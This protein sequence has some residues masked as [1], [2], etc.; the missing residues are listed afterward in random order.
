MMNAA[1]PK[2]VLTAVLAVCF[3]ILSIGSGYLVMFAVERI[4]MNV[5]AEIYQT[6]GK[7]ALWHGDAPPASELE[8]LAAK[9]RAAGRLEAESAFRQALESLR[10]TG[11]LVL[12]APPVSPFLAW[13]ALGFALAALALLILSKR[14]KTDAAQTV[15]GIIAGLFVWICIELGL[16]LAARDLGI[17]KRFD[18]LNGALIGVRGEFVLLKYS[19]VFLLPVILYL[20]FQESV[21]CNLFV[22]LRKKLHLMRGAAATGRIDNY[23]PRVTFY[24]MSSIWTFYVILLWAFD[25]RIFGA[26]SG[27]TYLFFFICLACTVY[28]FYR[29]LQQSGPGAVLRYA[30]AVALVLWSIIEI[31]I[32]WDLLHGPWLSYN[33]YALASCAL[34]MTAGGAMIARDMRKH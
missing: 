5:S 24:Y 34:A 11:K 22:F 9:N 6:P 30:I 32:K 26:Q 10:Q 12:T 7:Q 16:V 27:F 15:I 28:L 17:V 23:A 4:D 14:A 2:K 33:P 25:E 29:L 21:R 18:L 19:W 31:L 13:C 20:L 3:I 1:N 8:R